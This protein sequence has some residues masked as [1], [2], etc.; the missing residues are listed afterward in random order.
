MQTNR[1]IPTE[2][3]EGTGWPRLQRR[4]DTR[5]AEIMQIMPP[6]ATTDQALSF[7]RELQCYLSYWSM[8]LVA[9]RVQSNSLAAPKRPNPKTT[10]APLQYA[11]TNARSRNALLV[12]R[13]TSSRART[14]LLNIPPGSRDT[15]RAAIRHGHER[16]FSIRPLT[17]KEQVAPHFATGT[18]ASS[19]QAFS[20]KRH[21]SLRTS[22]RVRRRLLD[23]LSRLKASVPPHVVGGT[24]SPSRHALVF[25]RHN[26]RCKSPRVRTFLLET[27][28]PSRH[29]SR[30]TS[31][32]VR[33][34][35]STSALA[36]EA[37][38]T[39][40]SAC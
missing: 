19:R 3:R 31:S 32:R 6:V 22:S 18:K 36:R 12:E 5:H 25:K 15:S 40:H 23:K 34:L 17:Q 16:P 11:C 37:S 2:A 35:L 38:V 21:Q 7:S 39:P 10:S 13:Y 29:Q 27:L 33:A 26:S 24:N 1:W 9:L 28:S 20:L 14:L 8:D 30:R 4:H